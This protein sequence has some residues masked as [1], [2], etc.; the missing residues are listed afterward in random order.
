MRTALRSSSTQP[1]HT[2][3]Q[4]MVTAVAAGIF[5]VLLIFGIFAAYYDSAQRDLRRQEIET[6]AVTVGDST[7]WGVDN[8]LMERVSLAETIAHRLSATPDSNDPVEIL[9]NPVFEKNFI[10]TYYGT[11]GSEY[12][13]W[14]HDI[15]PADYDPTTRPWYHAAEAANATTLTEP[16]HDIATNTET[17]TV[18]SP[19]WKAGKM[20]GV[21][22]A[23]FSTQTLSEVLNT[24]NLG[25]LGIVYLVN[26]DGK[27]IAH[28]SRELVQSTIADLYDRDMPRV[29]DSIQYV[30]QGDR[31]KIVRF[32]K[33]PS[34]STVDWY[35]AVAIDS[36]K[37]YASLHDFRISATIAMI[38]AA[39]LMIVVLG[40]VISRL[41]VI[42]L[43]RARAEA[44]AANAAKSEFLANMSHEIRT[45]MNGV[46]G[47]AELLART[48][49]SPKQK[50]FAD[51]ILKSGNALLTIINDVLDFS[52]IDSGELTLDPQPFNLKA[53]VEDVAG[54]VATKID[55]KKLELI[56]R[57]HP[58]MPEEY[59]G[60]DGRIRQILVNL[61]G[62]AVKFTE[63]G[64]ILVNVSG[65]REG[66]MASLNIRVEDTGIGIPADQLGSVFDKFNQID[67]SATRKFEG[68]GLGLAIC[69]M[70]VEK[71]DGEIGVEAELGSGSVFW[72]KIKLPVHESGVKQR[73]MPTDI[74]GA[75]ILIIDDNEV[76][77]EILI[78]QLDSWEMTSTAC[79]SPAKGL[80]AL[81][82]S[83]ENKTPFDLIIMDYQ[84]P[85]VDGFEASRRIQANEN[86]KGIP[87]IMLTSVCNQVETADY[88]RVG[89]KA[90]LLKPARS[91]QLFET[92]VDVISESR[93]A[94]L[95]SLSDAL[96]AAQAEEQTDRK[97]PEDK[98]PDASGIKV[99]VA[100]D[101]EVNQSVIGVILES[102]G[103]DYRIAED[104]K[105]AVDLVDDY[106]P[107]VILM[108]VSMP[109]MNGLEATQELRKRDAACG[110]HTIIVGLTANALK[111]DRENC[112][113]AGMDD[114]LSK[115]VNIDKLET[116]IAKWALKSSAAASNTG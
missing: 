66:D 102:L 69:K 35:V 54:L 78:E 76:N 9:S 70:L 8:W 107:D 12:Y 20:A 29:D 53:V 59:V 14:P 2:G 72:F 42:P 43:M 94:N 37:A 4:L 15:M 67:N 7:T 99:L 115:P 74:K 55:E 61:V 56:V 86:Y 32:E 103:H 97:A 21:V 79:S 57:F 82:A 58:K 83:V 1:V 6:Y 16:Y 91:S 45:P 80:A 19:V 92:I 75:R 24:T 112:I 30:R 28:P 77:R 60:D 25:G 22:G 11:Q 85:E 89:I 73:T 46:M 31:E 33:I 49:L 81:E 47:M 100:E 51:I 111:G 87:I 65:T 96:K 39:L 17:I 106:Q 98:A 116:C 40:L 26:G 113:E 18:A 10:W 23:D 68:T 104:G 109:V 3:A 88:R 27:I 90:H 101:N 95:K 62:N 41:L 108:D 13:I 110:T 52:K 44:D 71:M 48:E 93:V 50:N 38:A 36:N 5:A 64:H 84:M 34:L 105:V 114:Y 63:A